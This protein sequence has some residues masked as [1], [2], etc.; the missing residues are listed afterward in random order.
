MPYITQKDRKRVDRT[1]VARNR[2]EFNYLVSGEVKKYL[3]KFG[4]RYQRMDEVIEVL[5]Q[6]CDRIF[7]GDQA[8]LAVC[9]EDIIENRDY[10]D[11]IEGTLHSV[12][13]EFYRR[14]VAPY[15]DEKCKTNGDV[16]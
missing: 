1:R 12:L 16:Y 11:D 3:D 7:T 2:G 15:E 10:E 8:L 14:V 9:I 13:L 4:Y 5:S 6:Y